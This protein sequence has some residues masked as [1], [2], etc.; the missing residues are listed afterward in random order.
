M[1]TSETIFDKAADTDTVGSRIFR[2][3]DASGVPVGQIAKTL[4]V[5]KSTV[6]A[7]ENDR[8]APRAHHLV[9]IAGMVGV[10]PSWLLGGV[11]EA[12]GLDGVS[13]EVRVIRKQLGENP[14]PVRAD[15]QCHRQYGNGT[16][17]AGKE[18]SGSI[19]NDDD[20]CRCRCLSGQA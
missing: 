4:G 19:L 2:A 1:P 17:A 16:G 14:G 20:L 7:W 18:G 15:I 12:P 8:S 10:S 6:E 11:G 3:R 5:R 9:R 13:E